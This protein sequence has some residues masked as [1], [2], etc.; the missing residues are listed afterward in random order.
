M[1][2]PPPQST[3]FETAVEGLSRA[4]GAQVRSSWRG[5]SLALLGLLLGYW[6]GQNL[7]SPWRTAAPGGRPGAVLLMLLLVE[8]GVRLRSRWLKGEPGLGWVLADNL[9]I[10][11][12]YAVVLEAFK[13]GS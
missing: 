1:S 4:L 13:L 8:A 9:R 2:S 6:L 7:T 5:A 3:R 12:T 11:A 10:G